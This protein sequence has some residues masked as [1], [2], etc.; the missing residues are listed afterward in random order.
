MTELGALLDLA[1][2]AARKAGRQLKEA[3]EQWRSISYEQNHDIKVEGDTKSEA[4]ILACL[5]ASSNIPILSEEVGWQGKRSGS[6][7]WV[8]DPLDG[9]ANY[10]RGI[11]VCGVSIALVDE[12]T[13]VLGVVYDPYRDELFSGVVGE[14]AWLNGAPIAVSKIR[15]RSRGVLMTG[16]PAR[17]DYDEGTLQSL[18]SEM[19]KWRKIRMVGCASI[20]TAYVAAG[21]AEMYREKG[22][23]L[24]DVAAGCALVAAAGGDY[25]LSE[26]AFDEP[27]NVIAHNGGW[28]SDEQAGI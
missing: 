18:A 24:W 6:R 13:P 12:L 19:R 28:S 2:N 10:A 11:P 5:E 16:L 25:K 21:R 27:R 1:A 9:S 17:M 3:D 7:S 8:V 23:M 20:A 14:G 4:L 26:G 15:E 22:T